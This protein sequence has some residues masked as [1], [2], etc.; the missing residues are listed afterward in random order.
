MRRGAFFL[1]I[2][3]AASA[4]AQTPPP[5]LWTQFATTA[6][7]AAV[8]STACALTANAVLDGRPMPIALDAFDD[9]TELCASPQ[10]A[11]LAVHGRVKMTSAQPSVVIVELDVP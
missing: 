4:H 1:I 6:P 5:K 9:A 8:A 11:S 2:A 7:H 10:A 3:V